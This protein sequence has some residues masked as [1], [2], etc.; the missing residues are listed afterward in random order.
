M[1]PALTDPLT[2]PCGAVLKNRV[3]KGAMTEGIGTPD[4][5]ATADH[6]ALYGRW[7]RGG[8]MDKSRQHRMHPRWLKATTP[9]RLNLPH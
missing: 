7:A 8:A 5:R 2:L 1:T 6:A 4:N 3:V 9:K